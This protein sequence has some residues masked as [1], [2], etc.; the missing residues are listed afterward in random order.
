[1]SDENTRVIH[2]ANFE[3]EMKDRFADAIMRVISGVDNYAEPE[4][5]SPATTSPRRPL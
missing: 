5:A 4:K 2:D 1:M 3:E